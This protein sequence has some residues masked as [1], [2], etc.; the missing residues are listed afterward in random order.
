MLTLCYAAPPDVSNIEM[1]LSVS[2]F[3]YVEFIE[4]QLDQTLNRREIRLSKSHLKSNP[5]TTFLRWADHSRLLS[6]LLSSFIFTIGRLN[7]ADVWIRTTDLWCQKGPFCPLN[8]N[9]CPQYPFL[10]TKTKQESKSS[11]PLNCACYCP[12]QTDY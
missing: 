10:N 7:F 5:I 4:N 6:S 8:H 2:F 9:H 3:K 11:L 1:C 12:F